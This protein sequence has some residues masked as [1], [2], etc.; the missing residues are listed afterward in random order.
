MEQQDSAIPA[1]AAASNPAAGRASTLALEDDWGE[2][3]K[4]TKD[5]AKGEPRSSTNPAHAKIS[6]PGR[7]W[8]DQE[9]QLVPEHKSHV[10]HDEADRIRCSACPMLS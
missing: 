2:W 6:E 7:R 10:H 1:P 4:L 8:Q 9:Q 3:N 5:P